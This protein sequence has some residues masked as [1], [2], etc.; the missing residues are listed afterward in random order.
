METRNFVQVLIDKL[1]S[2]RFFT[3]SAALHLIFI[4]AFGGTVLFHAGTDQPEFDAEGTGGFLTEDMVSAPPQ[5]QQRQQREQAP[6]MAQQATPSEAATATS[7]APL[8]AQTRSQSDFRLPTTQSLRRPRSNTL[9]TMPQQQRTDVRTGFGE[10]TPEAARQV[11]EF[12]GGWRQSGGMGQGTGG[13]SSFKFTAYLAKY[14]GGNWDSTVEVRGGE[15]VKGSLPNLMY[16][17]TA[18]TRDRVDASAQPVPLDLAS[19][20]IF[21]VKPPFIFFTGHQD[22]VLTD[23]EVENL[24]RYLMMGGAIWGDSSLPG[25]RSR[26][27]IAFRR[28]MKRVIPDVDRDFE[29]LPPDHPVFTQGFFRDVREVPSGMNYYQ[30][31]VYVM[32]VHGEI[33]VVYTA[34]DYGDMWQ[35]GLTE[36]GQIDTR[37]DERN[38]YIV[39]DHGIWHNRGIY[40]RNIN[41]ESVAQS[42]RFGVNMVLYLVTRWEHQLQRVPRL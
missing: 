40:F 1:F 41:Q 8:V 14:A 24:R 9:S 4:L 35:I 6:S 20:E 30:E 11:Y 22:F 15:I 17:M 36:D 34:N 10:L 27:D 18:W 33:S 26:F 31:P 19:D 12:T 21:D 39:I 2:S 38:R 29:K 37:R 3:I 32:R 42:Y 5:P 23:Q 25:H 28:E 7:M 16:V 13:Q